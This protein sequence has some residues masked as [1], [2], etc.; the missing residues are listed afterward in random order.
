M[1]RARL[2]PLDPAL[3]L[4]LIIQRKTPEATEAARAKSRREASRKQKVL[5]PRGL[6]AAEFII[7]GT[8]LPPDG[9]PAEEVLAVYRPRWQT[10]LAFKR[11][12]TLLRMDRI[13]THTERASRSWLTAH[14]IMALL[15]DDLSQDFLESS[16]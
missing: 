1:A 10:E 15:C 14:L 13:P 6:I 7:L 12:K 4:R 5:D 16:P 8:S 9:Y 2:G 11:L 3:P